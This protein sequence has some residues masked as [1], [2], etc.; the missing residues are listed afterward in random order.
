MPFIADDPMR[1]H[2]AARRVVVILDASGS[3]GS[4]RDVTIEA[5]NAYV[6]KIAEEDGATGATAISAYSFTTEPAGD[7]YPRGKPKIDRL[8]ADLP[9]SAAIGNIN[10]ENYDPTKGQNTPLY[11]AV[12][13]VC[14]G[15]RDGIAIVV[16]LTDGLE[17]ASLEYKREDVVALVKDREAKGWTFVFLG[18][19]LSRDVSVQL[20][21]DM[22]MSA[23]NSMS[24][25]KSETRRMSR[26]LAAATTRYSGA[27]SASTQSFFEKDEQEIGPEKK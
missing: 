8:Y 3:M 14:N 18:A 16:I 7:A 27:G 25:S 9:A 12:A 11:D 19:D 4:A 13:S 24:Y 26:S 23:S 2:A 22:G 17:N 6:G 1:G 10:I 20:S 5:L 15:I 21:C